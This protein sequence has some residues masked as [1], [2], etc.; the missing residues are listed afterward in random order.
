MWSNRAQIWAGFKN[1]IFRTDYTEEVY[2]MR[3]KE[4]KKCPMLDTLGT[5]CEV[6]GTQPCCSVCGCS[7]AL[8]LRSLESECPHPDGPKW[9]SIEDAK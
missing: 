4:C 9:K 5:D 8:K 2:H 1:L 6:I 3:M 7:L